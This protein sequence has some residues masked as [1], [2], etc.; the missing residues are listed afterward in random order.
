MA[1][2]TL[3]YEKTPAGFR[4]ITDPREQEQMLNN[5]TRHHEAVLMNSSPILDRLRTE[6]RAKQL[7]TDSIDKL[8]GIINTLNTPQVRGG[9]QQLVN[10][11]RTRFPK[12]LMNG[13][14][15]NMSN[16]D[17]GELLKSLTSNGDTNK[18]MDKVL[19]DPEL[20]KDAMETMKEMLSDEEKFKSM[21]KM[22]SDMLGG[23]DKDNEE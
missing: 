17:F 16:K 12:N 14:V 9:L 7:N 13:V 3:Y 15:K 23:D 4:Q 22:M 18:L 2:G 5:Q 10:F 6:W 1:K 19:N 20:S 8:Q 11:V 21:T